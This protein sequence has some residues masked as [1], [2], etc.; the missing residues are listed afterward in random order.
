MRF[1]EGEES[2]GRTTESAVELL[3]PREDVRAEN[4]PGLDAEDDRFQSM[5]ALHFADMEPDQAQFGED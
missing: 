4:E 1:C 5:L 2:V 3:R